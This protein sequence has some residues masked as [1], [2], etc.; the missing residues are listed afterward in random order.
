[1]ACATRWCFSSGNASRLVWSLGRFSWELHLQLGCLEGLTAGVSP[2][3]SGHRVVLRD[4]HDVDIM[5]LSSAG[6][7]YFHPTGLAEPE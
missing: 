4:V 7:C 2:A 6:L 3:G 1:M 5:V